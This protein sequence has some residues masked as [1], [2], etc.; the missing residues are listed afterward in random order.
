MFQVLGLR[1]RLRVYGVRVFN[2]GFQVLGL[3]FLSFNFR[4]LGSSLRFLIF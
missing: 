1:F 4:V 3:G 2:S